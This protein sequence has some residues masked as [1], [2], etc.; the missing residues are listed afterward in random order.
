[1]PKFEAGE[2]HPGG[3]AGCLRWKGRPTE[4]LRCVR[5]DGD[6][7]EL[8]TT[9]AELAAL[10]SQKQPVILRQLISD[11]E[12]TAIRSYCRTWSRQ[13]AP[14]NPHVSRSSRNYH[15]ININPELSSVKSINHL[16]RFFYWD[17]RTVAMATPFRRAMRLRNAISGLAPD[18]AGHDIQDGFISMPFVS[19]YPRGGG[20]MQEHRDP[21]SAQQVVV[22]VNM[23]RYGVD[24]SHGGV[25]LV[26]DSDL[27]KPVWIDPLVEPGDALL[28]HPQTTHGV[29]AI[30][31]DVEL[32]WDAPDG[33]WMFTSSLV[34][35]GTLNGVDDGAAGQPSADVDSAPINPGN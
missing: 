25:Y 6:E 34:K 12:A 21:V 29:A 10:I 30:D 7:C 16:F 3:V 19:H 9:I 18:Y 24:F 2:S 14:S 13:E 28:F 8:D 26:E 15:R 32:D 1:M 20:G 5:R 31:P 27:E 4:I 35:V 23:S 33:R 22:I 17:Q 11:A